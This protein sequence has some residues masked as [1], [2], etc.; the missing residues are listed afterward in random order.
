MKEKSLHL[1]EAFCSATLAQKL[2]THEEFF[3]E[4]SLASGGIF[5]WN[6]GQFQDGGT[7]LESAVISVHLDEAKGYSLFHDSSYSNG[8]MDHRHFRM[9]ERCYRPYTDLGN[10]PSRTEKYLDEPSRHLVD[11][12]DI[13]GD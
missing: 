7:S 13:N 10:S 12:D 3:K 2:A 1:R 6:K 11:D 4:T 5:K 9:F 8:T